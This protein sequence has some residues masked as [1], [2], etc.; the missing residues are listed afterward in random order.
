MKEI[1]FEVSEE[2]TADFV[3]IMTCGSPMCD[4]VHLALFHEN[5]LVPFAACSLNE[6]V[7]RDLALALLD[8]RNQ[9]R[10]ADFS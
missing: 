4:H 5:G 2:G 6:E 10:G 7:I 8:V 9:K 3:Q 1:G